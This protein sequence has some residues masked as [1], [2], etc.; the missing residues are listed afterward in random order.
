M[1][2]RQ[3]LVTT[4]LSLTVVVLLALWLTAVAGQS[5]RQMLDG[6]SGLGWTFG[7][8]LAAS[9]SLKTMFAPAAMIFVAGLAGLGSV[10][11]TRGLF[12]V[13]AAALVTAVGACLLIQLTMNDPVSVAQVRA[14]TPFTQIQEFDHFQEAKQ[15][16]LTWSVVSLIGGL[17]VLL[18]L[19]KVAK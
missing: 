18:G 12:Y 9:N 4:S 14:T 1:S 7:A 19:R 16:F 5:A 10:D 15:R 8:A 17:G 11:K 2:A 3:K 6:Q 13:A